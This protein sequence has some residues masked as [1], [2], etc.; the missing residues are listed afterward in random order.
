MAAAAP[1]NAPLALTLSVLQPASGFAYSSRLPATFSVAVPGL[2]LDLA[3]YASA[4]LLAGGSVASR[5]AA[6]GGGDLVSLEL[7]LGLSVTG[8]SLGAFSRVPIGKVDLPVPLDVM[9]A[10][11]SR[12]GKRAGG[13]HG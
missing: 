7:A 3:G 1:P 2:G 6:S 9:A 8:I 5:A 10:A 13:A 12:G 4:G 11:M